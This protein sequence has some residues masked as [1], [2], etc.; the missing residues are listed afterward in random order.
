MAVL[1]S[2][3]INGTPMLTEV[4]PLLQRSLCKQQSLPVPNKDTSLP[5]SPPPCA[6]TLEHHLKP[7]TNG[8]LPEAVL[9]NHI[10][11]T[12][13]VTVTSSSG[14]TTTVG[15]ERHAIAAHPERESVLPTEKRRGRRRGREE[16]PKRSRTSIDRS[17]LKHAKV[18]EVEEASAL[19]DDDPAMTKE[20]EIELEQIDQQLLELGPFAVGAYV[21]EGGPGTCQVPPLDSAGGGIGKRRGRSRS[22]NHAKGVTRVPVNGGE[23]ESPTVRH[24]TEK[25]EK[26][27]SAPYR[28]KSKKEKGHVHPKRRWRKVGSG[29]GQRQKGKDGLL[30]E[31]DSQIL[32]SS[33]RHGRASSPSIIPAASEME[34][35]SLYLPSQWDTVADSPTSSDHPNTGS[36]PSSIDEA[37]STLLSPQNFEL[38]TNLS[39]STSSLASDQG[40]RITAAPKHHHSP[41]SPP[42]AAATSRSRIQEL[43]TPEARRTP[44]L[45]HPPSSAPTVMTEPAKAEA[46]TVHRDQDTPLGTREGA[47]DRPSMAEATS[48]KEQAEISESKLQTPVSVQPELQ[49]PLARVPRVSTPDFSIAQ[50]T[51]TGGARTSTAVAQA[52]MHPSQGWARPAEGIAHS[53][54]PDQGQYVDVESPLPASHSLRRTSSSSSHRSAKLRYQEDSV[55]PGSPLPPPRAPSVSHVPPAEWNGSSTPSPAHYHPG[56]DNKVPA[57]PPYPPSS[58]SESVRFPVNPYMFL[59][60]PGQATSES[61]SGVASAPLPQYPY[62]SPFLHP[63]WLQARG[64]MLGAV[65]PFRPMFA[66]LDP[67]N[68]YKSMFGLSPLSY[69]YPFPAAVAAQGLTTPFPFST[70][71]TPSSSTS[72]APQASATFPVNQPAVYQLPSSSSLSAFR[73]LNEPS[74]RAATPP[75]MQPSTP[76]GGVKDDK[77]QRESGPDKPPAVQWLNTPL[78]APGMSYPFGAAQ[79]GIA[80]PKHL[81]PGSIAGAQHPPGVNILNSRLGSSPLS[82]SPLALSGQTHASLASSEKSAL[83]AVRKSHR[84]SSSATSSELTAALREPLV[85]PPDASPSM[86]VFNRGQVDPTKVSAVSTVGQQHFLLGTDPAKWKLMQDTTPQVP[87]ASTQ[88]GS[89][90]PYLTSTALAT[91]SS[92]PVQYSMF[93]SSANP[94]PH[95]NTTSYPQMPT[96]MTLV[97]GQL[98]PVGFAAQASPGR[99]DVGAGGGGGRGSS[100][101][102]PEKMKLRIHQMKNDDFKMQGK[103]GDRRRRRPWR[104]R[105]KLQEVEKVELPKGSPKLAQQPVSQGSKDGPGVHP[106][107]ETEMHGLNIL[108]ACSS[109]IESAVG[110]KRTTCP[111]PAASASEASRS[112]KMRSPVSLAGA[113]TLLLLGKDVQIHSDHQQVPTTQPTGIPQG[114]LQGGRME[115]AAASKVSQAESSVVDSLLQLSSAVPTSLAQCLVPPHNEER[116]SGSPSASF[117][118]AETMLMI[119]QGTQDAVGPR[120]AGEVSE[121]GKGETRAHSRYD[122][123]PGSEFSTLEKPAAQKPSGSKSDREGSVVD[124]EVTDT[125]SE[126]TLSPTSP[127]SHKWTVEPPAGTESHENTGDQSNPKSPIEEEEAPVKQ[128][129]AEPAESS[130]PASV[131]ELHHIETPPS[132]PTDM[133]HQEQ[134]T[135]QPEATSPADEA[136]EEQSDGTTGNSTQPDAAPCE[137]AVVHVPETNDTVSDTPQAVSGEI[138]EDTETER[139]AV[140]NS[141]LVAKTDPDV[142]ADPGL[143]QEVAET[144]PDVTSKV[145]EGDALKED[146]TSSKPAISTDTVSMMED[147]SGKDEVP[148]A[149]VTLSLTSPSVG[150]DREPLPLVS[151]REAEEKPTDAEDGL[152]PAKRPKLSESEVDT[153]LVPETE[154]ASPQ[155][156]SPEKNQHDVGETD[157]G[158]GEPSDTACAMPPVQEGTN[159]PMKEEGVKQE[160]EVDFQADGQEPLS[161]RTDLAGEEGTST[162]HDE[163]AREP[164]T[165]PLPT[166]P[167]SASWSDFASHAMDEA[168]PDNASQPDSPHPHT[169]SL[170]LISVHLD[171]KC[172]SPEPLSKP[173][174]PLST[175]PKAE[176]SKETKSSEPR[177]LS[178]ET[179]P[180]LEL[181]SK[182]VEEEQQS[183]SRDN[184]QRPPL[185][186]LATAPVAPQNRLLVGRP[187]FDRY[188]HKRLLKKHSGDRDLKREE[189]RKQRPS[190]QEAGS[191]LKGLFEVDPKEV[192]GKELGEKSRVGN[193]ERLPLP[194]PPAPSRGDK[195]ERVSD[196]ESRKTK[197]SSASRPSQGYQSS[198]GQHKATG[199]RRSS[200][201]RP[202]PS[203]ETQPHRHVKGDVRAQPDG[204]P[205]SRDL[206]NPRERPPRQEGTGGLPVSNRSDLPGYPH[207]E[208]EREERLRDFTPPSDADDSSKY[209]PYNP[210]Q[211]KRWSA[212]DMQRGGGGGSSRHGS[213]HPQHKGSHR[214]E[215]HTKKQ[216]S[217]GFDAPGARREWRSGS[218]RGSTPEKRKYEKTPPTSDVPSGTTGLLHR[219]RKRSRDDDG[220]AHELT[221][222]RSYESISEDDSMFDNNSTDLWDKDRRGSRDDNSEP[223]TASVSKERKRKLSSSESSGGEDP[224]PR[225]KKHKHTKDKWRHREHKKWGLSD[226]K[227]SSRH[228]YHKHT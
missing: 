68:P 99:A 161:E 218:S 39:Q 105:E 193:T 167:P 44:T 199:E 84:R 48:C 33:G 78:I 179:S 29:G 150:L 6:P 88:P 49:I 14:I 122:S 191:R 168:I 143:T 125:D 119:R 206:K 225:R 74:G 21:K 127:H 130:Q 113:N 82:S 216:R 92:A 120:M 220:G 118:A 63:N 144:D 5:P 72:Q 132:E 18:I 15:E 165:S 171:S 164:T 208:R 190:P 173:E 51:S 19:G 111:P 201:P 116:R 8:E 3:A 109:N 155:P 95:M 69:R 85:K 166:I 160:H 96:H 151:V 23:V 13:H 66:P 52:G 154:E 83:Q 222:K 223:K 153:D 209:K 80:P 213:K 181:S 137:P 1:H 61:S 114:Q 100:K 198:G 134:I 87:S 188:Q 40:E 42:N 136:H 9:T 194:L 148:H 58:V 94:Q 57:T 221:R 71:F 112:A 38:A 32:N 10:P 211:H 203:D 43:G 146:I 129:T 79:F 28:D 200:H 141:Q 64:S 81:P 178:K 67:N 102:S 65:S 196:R 20:Y 131:R 117:S 59:A 108:A 176:S 27:D 62:P 30:D 7:S 91:P 212:E 147:E 123:I 2:D 70:T 46:K 163:G 185:S 169:S 90:P 12:S 110:G 106:M 175:S 76:F 97:G 104:S 227:Y 93:S 22:T 197:P 224:Q 228:S 54:P 174:P 35:L 149:R 195:E 172:D 202:Y 98:I 121:G 192:R 183:V 135:A 207:R 159:S 205:H 41:T 142:V 156:A 187:G 56:P 89:V 26:E 158:R 204:R 139:V 177:L 75:L 215:S 157:L 170:P 140:E 24:P 180:S 184:V 124:S 182:F 73:T 138:V 126:A 128:R 53:P 214:F 219:H 36:A 217:P 226:D 186:T 107:G 210:E 103:P 60:A 145:V 17:L 50:L 101:A 45:P 34:M 86:A 77:L 25:E 115:A 189:K 37:S 152:P 11:E 47:Q 31:A 16:E 4:C 55:K 133:L 162:S